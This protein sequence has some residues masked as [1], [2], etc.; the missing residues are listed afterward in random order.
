MFCELNL[1]VSGKTIIYFGVFV[2]STIG[3]YLPSLWNGSVFSFTGVI[4]SGI[5]GILGLVITYKII[6]E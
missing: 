5:G 2:S 1:R 3:G 4:T 6:N